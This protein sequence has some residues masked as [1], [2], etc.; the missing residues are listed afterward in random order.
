MDTDYENYMELYEA[1]YFFNRINCCNERNKSSGINENIYKAAVRILAV[2][3][4]L[5]CG[6]NGFIC[7]RNGTQRRNR[8]N[9]FRPEGAKT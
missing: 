4:L 9:N 1:V 7:G 2:N 3:N 6:R 5:D 8:T